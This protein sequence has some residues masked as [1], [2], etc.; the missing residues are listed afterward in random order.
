MKEIY[1]RVYELKNADDVVQKKIHNDMK[2]MQ[3]INN[4]D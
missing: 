2:F 3:E 4:T 1:E